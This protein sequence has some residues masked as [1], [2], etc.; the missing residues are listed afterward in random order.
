MKIFKQIEK[1]RFG[2]LFPKKK[3]EPLC[4]PNTNAGSKAIQLRKTDLTDSRSPVKPGDS[5]DLVYNRHLR[6]LIDY[7]SPVKSTANKVINM[8]RPPA[9]I[10]R[11]ISEVFDKEFGLV[12]KSDDFFRQPEHVILA[13]KAMLDDVIRWRLHPR[14]ICTYCG[15][16]LKIS[17]RNAGRGKIYFF[18]HTNDSGGCSLK[19]AMNTRIRKQKYDHIGEFDN[20][21]AI[22]MKDGKSGVI[23]PQGTIV[24]PVEYDEI[25]GLDG[26]RYKASNN[27]KYG[28][29]SET[30]NI[31]V[32]FEYDHIGKFDGGKAKVRK[33]M[34][35]GYIDEQGNIV[36]P[37]EYGRRTG[38]VVFFSHIRDF[39]FITESETAANLFFH[40]SGAYT[41]TED[42]D[43]VSFMPTESNK[44]FHATRIWR[45]T[46]PPSPEAEP[47]IRINEAFESNGTIEGMIT[48]HVKG[49]FIVYVSGVEAFLPGS[50]IEARPITDYDKYLGQ[51]MA[52]KIQA[53]GP[54]IRS[55]I[56]S[57]K[58]LD[59][60][61]LKLKREKL[62]PKIKRGTALSGIVKNLADFGAFVDLG[63]GI[64][65][66]IP[67]KDLSWKRVSH[68][69]EIVKPGQKLIVIVT[70]V[71]TSHK[72]Q[73]RVMLGLKQ[74]TPHPWNSFAVNLKPGDKVKG[75]VIEVVDYG[76]FVE[77][78]PGLESL[79]HV[80]HI[81]WSRVEDPHDFAKIGDEIE[82]KILAIDHQKHKI[83]LGLKQLKPNPW[84]TVD[85]KYGVGTRHIAQV[86]EL[87]PK[88]A[89]VELE[90]GILG[91][92]HIFDFSWTQKINNPSE[93]TSI[94]AE[95]EVVVLE[96][97]HKHRRLILGHK[98]LEENPGDIVVFTLGSG[99]ESTITGV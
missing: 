32:P 78:T 33:G 57:H 17:A 16:M 82:A 29:I 19:A 11:S 18:S 61:D 22:V 65:G 21:R 7:G 43:Q 44:G 95:I 55:I 96:I 98:Q 4:K 15:Q 39:G 87:K 12:I 31:I 79:I 6:H 3:R 34:K 74:L 35:D 53:I 59:E 58:E 5:S 92:I 28:I 30:G 56:V 52:F 94:G 50:C 77:L 14:I 47:W 89:I 99:R 20:D 86:R 1:F 97:N 40:V 37:L 38:T 73:L 42:G 85:E 41:N 80:S 93:F 88:A 54:D 26:N 25:N 24:V 67:T 10:K 81:S 51:R 66:L 84:L 72:G 91:F 70:D 23:D 75:K 13:Y 8:E 46:D 76:I 68:P 49:G 2:S 27:G 62:L 69:S 64:N 48:R 90:E 9:K 45:I 63:G 71:N 36:T 83:Q 60:A